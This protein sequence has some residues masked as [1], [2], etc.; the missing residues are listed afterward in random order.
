M[1][2]RDIWLDAGELD[3]IRCFIANGGLDKSQD[4]EIVRNREDL[5]L[6]AHKVKNL[7]FMQ[8]RLNFWNFKYWLFKV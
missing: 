5:D 7:E 6:V 4:R 8:K 3:Q 2:F 1:D